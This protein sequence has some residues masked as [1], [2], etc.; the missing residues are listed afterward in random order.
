MQ[1]DVRQL[2]QDLEADAVARFD[3]LVHQ[4]SQNEIDALHLALASERPLLVRGEPGTGKT[5]LARAA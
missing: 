1:A 2:L 4:W 3:G 5:Q